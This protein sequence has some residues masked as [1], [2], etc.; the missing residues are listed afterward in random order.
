[1]KIAF[2]TP[3]P[4]VLKHDWYRD[5]LYQKVG[6]PNLVGYLKRA[7]FSDISQHD[8]NNQIRLAYAKNPKLV[9]L[10]L[11]A[12]DKAVKHFLHGDDHDIQK[13]TEF[14]LDTLSIE[15]KNL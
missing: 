11:Y 1:M 4:I 10:M 12:D 5:L 3:S 14:F 13:Q 8:F 9:R 6:V 7:G 15:D 2:I